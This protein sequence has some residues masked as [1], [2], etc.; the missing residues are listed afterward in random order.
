MLFA[1]L[2]EKEAMFV[3]MAETGMNA[4]EKPL[5]ARGFKWAVLGSNQ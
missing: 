1:P 3:R 4:Q 5:D 2:S